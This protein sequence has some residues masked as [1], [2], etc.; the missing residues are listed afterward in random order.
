MTTET[1][2]ENEN[3]V[4]SPRGLSK[5]CDTSCAKDFI[6]N[7]RVK[8]TKQI[9]LHSNERRNQQNKYFDLLVSFKSFIQNIL[10]CLFHAFEYILFCLFHI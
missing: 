3:D 6:T 1:K 9:I 7:E 5:A 4:H 2:N 8:R 10:F